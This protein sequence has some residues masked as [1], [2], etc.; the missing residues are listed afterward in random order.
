MNKPITNGRVP[1]WV[2][3]LQEFNITILDQPGKENLVA[4]FISCIKHEGDDI[5]ADDSFP[6]EH[7]ISLSI[8]TPWFV[9]ME[10]YLATR[11]LPTHFSP[12]EKHRIIMQSDNYYWI[13]H[14]LFHIGPDLIIHRCVR[15]DEIPKILRSCHD[16]PCGGH[17]DYYYLGGIMF[18][19]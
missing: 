14:S 8:N 12:H 16:G 3:L 10:N 1:R 19:V 6:D 13:G 5:P 17:Y 7:L 18:H 2:L 9:D 4:N 15:E 11:K